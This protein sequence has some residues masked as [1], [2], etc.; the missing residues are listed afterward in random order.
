MG[1]KKIKN[2]IR[3]ARA[4]NEYLK[5]YDAPI[6]DKAILLEAAQGKHTDGNIFAFLRCVEENPRWQYLT[7][8]VVITRESKA[9]AQ[10]KFARYGFRRAKLVVRN[11][12]EYMKILATAKYLIT[13]NSFPPYFIK[14]L[15]QIYLNTWHGTP[16]KRLG[17][18]DITNSTSIGNVQKNFLTA[19]YLLQPNSY[20]KEVMMKDYMV[21]RVYGGRVVV[22]D[23][24]R[25]DVLFTK[26]LEVE[27][28]TKFNPNGK[29][30]IAYMPTW[31]GTGRNANV[32]Q[33][34]N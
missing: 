18:A 20:T 1:I 5:Y 21:D 11:S 16:L 17:R 22:A 26:P 32:K 24:P 28:R 8:Y 4:N 27:L 33:Q 34:I 7:P 15:G 6:D 25:N 3:N 23:Y 19:D 29:K 10:K 14:K 13:D 30:I 12:T 31:R 9:E 2:A